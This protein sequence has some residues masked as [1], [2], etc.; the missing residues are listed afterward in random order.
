[1]AHS[2]T[3]LP[4]S[5]ITGAAYGWQ[6]QLDPTE[7]PNSPDAFA[8]GLCSLHNPRLNY[9]RGAFNQTTWLPDLNWLVSSG[10]Q[11]NH[12][13]FDW[14]RTV[15]FDTDQ[16]AS[17]P[18]R[19]PTTNISWPF[20][21]RFQPSTSVAHRRDVNWGSGSTATNGPFVDLTGRGEDAGGG[22]VQ[23]STVGYVVGF[24]PVPRPY[25]VRIDRDSSN[26]PVSFTVSAP[27]PDTRFLSADWLHPTLLGDVTIFR[28]AGGVYYDWLRLMV[29]PGTDANLVPLS[30]W[31]AVEPSSSTTWTI[32][33][34]LNNI[35]PAGFVA[36][37]AFDP[38]MTFD[39]QTML[40]FAA[41][42]TRVSSL[43]VGV[44]GLQDG[45]GWLVANPNGNILDS[46]AGVDNLPVLAGRAM[47]FKWTYQNPGI[48]SG[49]RPRGVNLN[50][51]LN[52]AALS[53]SDSLSDGDAQE[54]FTYLIPTTA[55][56]LSWQIQFVNQALDASI[57]GVFTNIWPSVRLVDVAPAS[58]TSN[59]VWSRFALMN[60]GTTA[61]TE[62]LPFSAELTVSVPL[63]DGTTFTETVPVVYR[64][65]NGVGTDRLFFDYV[66]PELPSAP[67]QGGTASFSL[68][69]IQYDRLLTRQGAGQDNF[70]GTVPRNRQWFTQGV[71]N[72]SWTKPINT[73]IATAPAVVT[74]HW[75]ENT[76][77]IEI[78]S[79]QQ[80]ST[81]NPVEW[82]VSYDGGQ[83][84]E[85]MPDFAGLP[86]AWWRGPLDGIVQFRLV[87]YSATNQSGSVSSP[88]GYWFVAPAEECNFV[89]GRDA[90]VQTL[91]GSGLS[92]SVQYL[93]T[94]PTVVDS[95]YLVT[96]DDNVIRVQCGLIWERTFTPSVDVFPTLGGVLPLA[97]EGTNE[98][99]V[100]RLQGVE[101]ITSAG[102]GWALSGFTRGSLEG[103]GGVWA[104]TVILI[105]MNDSAFAG[106][107]SRFIDVTLLEVE[108]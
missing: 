77:R 37:W 95:F 35:I 14:G 39:T 82:Q 23:S 8:W 36:F 62:S 50:I 3:S 11:V 94:V 40:Q 107:G 2:F 108:G 60:G 15:Q 69:N 88:C 38:T 79:T 20:L 16:L 93:P 34:D 75:D 5:G 63:Y 101:S 26:N 99:R 28:T 84:W 52:G 51:G 100:W 102:Q 49:P 86:S 66:S 74:C 55:T 81:S 80:D 12:P 17:F 22:T 91:N 9:A 103:P 92:S 13:Q 72:Q 98:S 73:Q 105:D 30:A 54:Y 65:W 10:N 7:F 76:G 70:P 47:Y 97:I 1:M 46:Q 58:V 83:T 56:S 25:S 90:L 21:G 87:S 19:Q 85:G 44:S 43:G 57:S 32:A 42:G 78:T 96:D 41:G 68:T 64:G 67:L 29:A 27:E 104:D 6:W 45:P 71:A 61:N 48:W 18:R 33:T 106:V 24:P 4:N 53:Q 31:R 59:V 89:Q